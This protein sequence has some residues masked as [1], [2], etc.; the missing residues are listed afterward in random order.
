M[1]FEANARVHLKSAPDRKGR[2]TGKTRERAGRLRYQVDFGDKLDYVIEGNL[3]ASEENADTYDLIEK[4]K[5]G[6]V[7]N[8]RST[9]THTRLTGRLADVVYSMEASNTE[10][11]P[12]Q[13]KPVLNFL[14]S[15]SKGLL[16]ADE[17]GLGKTIEAGLIWTELRARFDANK[18]LVLCPAVLREKWQ[19]E[20]AHRF[21]VDSEICSASELHAILKRQRAGAING[22]CVI[23]SLQGL[24][25]PKGWDEDDKK[26]SRAAA[27]ARYISE[28]DPGETI[29][30]AVIVD[31]AHYLR[32]PETQTHKLAILVREIS[33]SMI[34]LSATPIQL[35]SEDLFHLLTLIDAENFQ[36]VDAFRNV[37]EA[38]KPL[39][40]LAGKLRR[41]GMNQRELNDGLEHCLA[42]PLLDKNRQ[43]SYMQQNVPDDNELNDPAIRESFATRIERINLLARVVNRTRKRDVLENRVIREV[44]APEIEMNSLEEDFY[45]QVTDVVRKYCIERDLHEGFLATIPQRQMCSSMPAALRSW[46]KKLQQASTDEFVYESGLGDSEKIVKQDIGPLVRR[47]AVTVDEIASFEQLKHGD[48]KYRVLIG[49]LREYWASYPDNKIILFSYYRGTISYLEERLEEDGIK[50]MVLVGGMKETKHE[51]IQHFKTSDNI[52]ILL[53]SEVASEGVDLQFSSFLINYDL[54][55]N[56]MRV[57][58]RIGRIDRIGQKESKVHIWNFFYAGTLDD[59]IY[60]RLFE[61]LDVFKEALGD[62]EIILGDK[63]QE[64]TTYLLTYDLTMQQ[65]EEQIEQTEMAIATIKREQKELEAEAA[66]LAAH[67]D[68]VLNKVRAAREMRRYIDGERLWVYVRD[69]LSQQFRGT[70]LIRLPDDPLTVEIGLS[71][72]ARVEFQHYLEQSKGSGKTQLIRG[73]KENGRVRCVF[74]NHVD[75]AS[76]GHEVINQYHPLVRFVISRV[77]NQKF[78]KLIASKVSAIDTP[79][80]SSGDYFIVAQMW[81]TTGAKAVEKLIFKGMSISDGSFM[82]DDDAE[83]LLNIAI[84]SGTDW[85][86]I[87]SVIDEEKALETYGSLLDQL[88]DQFEEYATLMILENNDRVDYLIKSLTDKVN[89]KIRKEAEIIERLKMENK[90]K[91]IKAREGKI[92]KEREYLELRCP[93]YEKQRSVNSEQE[94]VTTVVVHVGE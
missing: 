34:F 13:F 12:Y 41:E 23:A 24:R 22:F 72:E 89:S 84:D 57:E 78:H 33:E 52:Q 74:S 93:V 88:D 8:L 61:R 70:E 64:M 20:L 38:N 29:F 49:K 25:P 48:S 73:H 91:T 39:V 65:E 69:T 55:W 87:R 17:V 62:L 32:N 77:G 2:I 75:F 3:V 90:L 81:S 82:S 43:L 27:L 79:V 14:E 10:F 4:G 80:F 68:Y 45:L 86:G 15:P 11:Y 76:H 42:H 44:L 63:I 18:L 40:E 16:I 31:E 9:I 51:M 54:P 19:E 6:G 36:Y 37:L 94:E 66:H 28:I 56:P 92:R 1:I 47:L 46:K 58:Q 67:G 53:A 21:G 7:L 59:R 35:R 60:T 26:K 83:R 71:Q 5:Y 50:P 85:P 30:D